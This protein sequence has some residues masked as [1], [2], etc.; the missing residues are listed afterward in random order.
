[1]TNPNRPFVWI[2]S[3]QSDLRA[4][5]QRVRRDIGQALYAVQQGVTDPA[6]RPL[7]TYREEPVMEIVKRYRSVTHRALYSRFDDAVYVLRAY[8]TEST[9]AN[10]KPNRC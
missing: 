3:S 4:M 6:A 2:G 5:P 7:R 10:S 1:M 9:S 8:P